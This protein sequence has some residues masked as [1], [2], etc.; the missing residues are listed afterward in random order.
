MA[1]KELYLAALTAG[2]V[3]TGLGAAGA[4]DMQGGMG[5]SMMQGGMMQR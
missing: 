2:F 5:P 4:K 3:V 1:M